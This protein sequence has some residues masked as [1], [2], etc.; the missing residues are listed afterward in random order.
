MPW[1]SFVD[2]LNPTRLDTNATSPFVADQAAVSFDQNGDAATVY[3]DRNSDGIIIG[4]SAQLADS[5]LITVFQGS[6]EL[7]PFQML[8]P[9][10]LVPGPMVPGPPVPGP[11]G[12]LV[13]GP[14]VPGPMVPGPMVSQTFNI[15]ETPQSYNGNPDIA[16]APDGS[17]VVVW[18]YTDATWTPPAGGPPVQILGAQHTFI[19]SF[20][21]RGTMVDEREIFLPNGGQIAVSMDANR[22]PAIVY[23][24]RNSDGIVTGISAQLLDTS[25]NPVGAPITVFQGSAQQVSFQMLVPGPLVP[26]PAVPGPPVPGP[27]GSLVPGPLV[28]GPM[29]PGPMVSQTFNIWESPQSYNSGPDIA[30]APDGSF[31]VAWSYTD[32]TWDGVP[33]A[34]IL[35]DR[36]TFIE[37]FDPSGMMLDTKEI[38]NGGAASILVDRSGNRATASLSGDGVLVLSQLDQ[39]T[40]AGAEAPPTVTL[41]GQAVEGQTLTATPNLT[42][43]GDNSTADVTY[44]WERNGTVIGTGESYLVTESDEGTTI[45]VVASF[46][47]DAG[48]TVTATSNA[49]S[50]VV[51][52]PPTLSVTLSGTAQEGQI[53]TASASAGQPDN[54]VTYQW[55]SSADGFTNPIGSGVSYQVQEGDEGNQIEVV[56]T[57]TNDNGVAVTAASATIVSPVTVNFDALDAYDALN[58]QIGSAAL[59][60]YLAGYGIT[61]ATSGPGAAVEAADDRRIYG[62]GVV[63]ATSGDVVIGEQGG[64][65]VSYS[66]SFGTPLSGF[67]FDRVTEYAGPSGTSYPEWSATAYDVS[68]T[69]LSSVGEGEGAVLSGSAAAVHYTLTGPHIAKV[70]FS[71]NDFGFAAFANVLT[72]TWTLTPEA[73]ATG[74]VLD[75]APTVITPT[76]SGMA[77]EGQTLSASA[78]SGQSD[79]PVTYAWYSSADGYTNPIGTGATYVVQEADEDSNIEVKATATNDN[80]ATVSA[81]SGATAAVIDLTLGSVHK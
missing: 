36:H 5:S 11:D 54:A 80:G 78:R 71:G 52:A 4:I 56:A 61:L 53:L 34:P 76:I 37:S 24:D 8:M 17:F 13:P 57:V 63:G 72:D 48:Q 1:V 30:R 7:V 75:A 64:Y 67:A 59:D 70:T 65:P 6:A 47:D 19:E 42:T 35:G 23:F 81:T 12:S 25:L 58:G 41:N 49:T 33:P 79:N 46:T 9:G 29:V 62:G 14:L 73:S 68:G 66:V 28:P 22:S 21:P 18:S 43:D 20:D 2:P 44:R 26:G 51:D 3:Y 10:P 45:Q 15:W 38:S 55:F 77:Q 27:D 60:S 32:T 16:L 74:A 69:V 39:D 31:V 50:T 40:A